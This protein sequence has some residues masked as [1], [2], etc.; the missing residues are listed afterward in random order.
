MPTMMFSQLGDDRITGDRMI[1]REVVGQMEPLVGQEKHHRRC[2]DEHRDIAAQVRLD[3]N[4]HGQN[5]CQEHEDHS[6][7]W[8]QDKPPFPRALHR[9]IAICVDHVMCQFMAF[10]EHTQQRKS[11]MQDVFVRSPLEAKSPEK[12]HRDREK[13]DGSERI[14]LKSNECG[15]E[16]TE[17]DDRRDSQVQRRTVTL[18]H[19]RHDLRATFRP[20]MLLVGPIHTWRRYVL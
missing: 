20:S 16:N 2:G 10:I 8:H 13:F 15:D 4:R 18:G 11:A 3:G 14:R 9:H 5:E 17:A 7:G 19:R 12:R 6:V 1:R